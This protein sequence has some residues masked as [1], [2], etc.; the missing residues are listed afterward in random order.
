MFYFILIVHSPFGRYLNGVEVCPVMDVECSSING[1][2]TCNV[3]TTFS[4]VSCRDVDYPYGCDGF[5]DI[6]FWIMRI[7][8][9]LAAASRSQEG[10]A[11][12]ASPC[13]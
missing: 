5:H 1:Y 4:R 7:S 3:C 6:F 10:Q 11:L 2:F 13:A 8:N 9:P 12:Q